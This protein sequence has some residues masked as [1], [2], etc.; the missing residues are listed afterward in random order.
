M[1]SNLLFLL[2]PYFLT[3]AC[4]LAMQPI[5]AQPSF[6]PGKV[7]TIQG[8]TLTGLIG[9]YNNKN[10]DKVC[11]FKA[12]EKAAL[13]QFSPEQ[14][15][16][17]YIEDRRYFSKYAIPDANGNPNIVFVEWLVEGGT[18]LLKVKKDFYLRYANDSLQYIPVPTTD[19]MNELEKKRAR[20]NWYAFLQKIT[21]NCVNLSFHFKSPRGLDS[22]EENL[23]EITKQYNECKETPFLI[24]G[25][26]LPLFGIEIGITA[27]LGTSNLSFSPP[28]K[29]KVSS[30]TNVYEQLYPITP[31]SFVP[32]F[33]LA[34][35]L[36]S[37]RRFSNMSVDI[38]PS[39]YRYQFQSDILIDFDDFFVDKI[40]SNTK[41]NWLGIGG[42][43]FIRYAIPNLKPNISFRAG[44]VVEFIKR[45]NVT[46]L[47]SILVPERE[48][49]LTN[50]L[51]PFN[52]DDARSGFAGE[53]GI[54]STKNTPLGKWTIAIGFQQIGNIV[55]NVEPLKSETTNLYVKTI[56]IIR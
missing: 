25:E 31:S 34:F 4:L 44:L 28:P 27:S 29:P 26:R 51:T 45:T 30:P 35:S 47:E 23:I 48:I 10:V 18:S 36:K 16:A 21:E 43:I 37:L 22:K 2:H 20:Q 38:E 40:Y 15:K 6:L 8:D 11:L 17:Y 53:V 54:G 5:Y 52:F 19:V 46:T 39:L 41:V 50:T 32:S 33:G 12:N 49:I 1:K 13:Q 7:I 9:E 42:P 55:R 3:I 14:V 24:I 56:W